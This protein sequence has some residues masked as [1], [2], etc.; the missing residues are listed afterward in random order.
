MIAL[1]RAG[2]VKNHVFY[3]HQ[4]LSRGDKPV[5]NRH[6]VRPS[7]FVQEIPICLFFICSK[8]SE[9][10]ICLRNPTILR[11]IELNQVLNPFNICPKKWNCCRCALVRLP[12]YLSA[13]LS[14][15][16]TVTFPPNSGPSSRG[17][18]SKKELII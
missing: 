6:P 8:K 9:N 10:L 12:Y 13:S 18:S 7:G 11:E 16:K 14:A 2:E 5:L 15:A 17:G 4:S 3:I 1:R